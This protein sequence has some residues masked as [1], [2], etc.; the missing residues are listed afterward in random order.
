MKESAID[1]FKDF[2]ESSS[3]KLPEKLAALRRAV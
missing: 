3:V 1:G 2:F